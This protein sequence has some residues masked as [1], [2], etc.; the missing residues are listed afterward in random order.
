VP[1]VESVKIADRYDG[2]L[3]SRRYFL[4]GMKKSH[5]NVRPEILYLAVLYYIIEKGER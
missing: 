5:F 2:V 1:F 4:P 3:I